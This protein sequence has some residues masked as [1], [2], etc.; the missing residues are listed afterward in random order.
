[1]PAVKSSTPIVNNPTMVANNRNSAYPIA[2][3]PV[4]S[5]PKATLPSPPTN[6]ENLGSSNPLANPIGMAEKE[7]F[8][9]YKDLKTIIKSLQPKSFKGEGEDVPKIL[10]EWIMSMDAYFALAGYNTLAQGIMGRANLVGSAK[11]W[12]KLHC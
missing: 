3:A 7:D 11:L 6:V 4:F 2:L 8:G 10:E 9:R 12:W 5:N 1:M